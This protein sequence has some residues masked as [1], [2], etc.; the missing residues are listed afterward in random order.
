MRRYLLPLTLLVLVALVAAGSFRV[1]AGNYNRAAAV[2]YADQWAHARNGNY[3]NY[4]SGCGCTD[5]TNY[6]SQVL[7]A[8]GYP[9]RT[10]S[11]NPNSVFEWWYRWITS[12]GWQTSRTWRIT[13][14]FN[15]YTAQYPAE[16]TQ[17]GGW[18]PGV[19][20]MDAGDFILL[21]IINNSTGQ[22][23]GDGIP[24]H[25]RVIV[26]MNGPIS[27]SQED[28]RSY[29]EQCR[30]V[31]G[32]IPAPRNTML[33]NQHCTDR[34]RVAWDYNVDHAVLGWSIHVKW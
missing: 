6:A 7:R 23:P 13:P 14:D 26:S 29:D 31:Q 1:K 18:G 11:W 4:G 2:S 19:P 34:K 28:Y 20:G 3:P 33:I 21:D 5:C 25:A 22:T 10:G 16:L 8:G 30:L 24:D 27:Q 15:T 32:D 12:F 17:V 9:L